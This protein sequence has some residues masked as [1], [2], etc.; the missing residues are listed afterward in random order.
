MKN[1]KKNQGVTLIAL[2]ITIIVLLI[3]AGVALSMIMGDSGLF[4][5]ANS[6]RDLTKQSQALED[7][8]LIILEAKAE[9]NGNATLLDVIKKLYNSSNTYIVNT[10]ETASLSSEGEITSYEIEEP[11]KIYV[12]NVEYGCEIEI[13]N[14]LVARITNPAVSV[15][16]DETP[17]VPEEYTISYDMN[18]G[19]GTI[20]NQTKIENET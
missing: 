19:T 4:G 12:T 3:L 7:V 2:V 9:N 6:A 11:E 16:R 14:Q 15:Q 18:N 17:K 20:E 1:L 13:T 5:K 8:R 10:T